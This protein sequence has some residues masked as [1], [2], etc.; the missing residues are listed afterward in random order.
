MDTKNESFFTPKVIKFIIIFI[1]A[2]VISPGLFLNLPPI[3]F[4]SRVNHDSEGNESEEY[5]YIK[6]IWMTSKTS[7]LSAIVHAA[8]LMFIIFSLDHFY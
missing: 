5:S 8:L 3:N 4:F 2:I 1:L 6:N 7:L